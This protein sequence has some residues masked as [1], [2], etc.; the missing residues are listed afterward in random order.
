MGRTLEMFDKPRRPRQWRMVVC[1]AGDGPC[2]CD[3]TP[4]SVRYLCPRCDHETGWMGAKTV[5]EAKRGIPCPKCNGI[6]SNVTV[7]GARRFC[8]RPSRP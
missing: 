3:E 6:G 5:T 7:R 8:A 1:D 2:C 4:I